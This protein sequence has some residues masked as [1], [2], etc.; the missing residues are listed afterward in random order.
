MK[1]FKFCYGTLLVGCLVWGYNVSSFAQERRAATPDPIEVACTVIFTGIMEAR[2]AVANMVYRNPR[3]GQ[4][5]NINDAMRLVNLARITADL[6]MAKFIGC[7]IDA[8]MVYDY[9]GAVQN[10]KVR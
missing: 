8:T 9:A 3:H 6:E 7:Q 4:S 2:H 5:P 1:L 10:T